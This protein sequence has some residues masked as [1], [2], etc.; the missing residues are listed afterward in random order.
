M[1]RWSVYV[2]DYFA[3]QARGVK[4]SLCL[5]LKIMF[6]VLISRMDGG[7]RG[8]AMAKSASCDRTFPPFSWRWLCPCRNFSRPWM[9]KAC[10]EKIQKMKLERAVF[11]IKSV[12]RVS[13]WQDL[14]QPHS[15]FIYF[16]ITI[17]YWQFSCQG[18][19]RTYC[20]LSLRAKQSREPFIRTSLWNTEWGDRA[21]AVRAP[22]LRNN[23]PEELQPATSVSSF[24]YSFLLKGLPV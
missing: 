4:S 11:Q 7:C 23:M 6:L 3:S 12:K 21:L 17:R 8:V 18:I 20:K 1:R 9:F 19:S 2:H 13:I 16:Y 24:K 14:T 10:E 5:V 15:S 22:R